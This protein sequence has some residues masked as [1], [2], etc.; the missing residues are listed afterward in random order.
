MRLTAVAMP[1]AN[2]TSR[3]QQAVNVY[4][5]PDRDHCVPAAQNTVPLTKMGISLRDAETSSKQRYGIRK[6]WYRQLKDLISNVEEIPDRPILDRSE[7][8]RLGIR[9]SGFSAE[10]DDAAPAE[11]E[12]QYFTPVLREN[13]PISPCCPSLG[14]LKMAFPAT[15]L[16]GLGH[17]HT[18][19]M[20]LYW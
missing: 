2:A 7:Q 5:I 9:M 11:H 13:L 3:K 1:T 14:G 20:Q 4:S 12:A 17:R 18:M 16:S 10:P 8:Q 15:K 19:K 6:Q